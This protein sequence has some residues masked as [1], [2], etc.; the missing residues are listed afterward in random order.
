MSYI[1]THMQNPETWYKWTY[2]Q[3]RNRNAE[4]ENEQMDPGQG[5]KGG[6][7]D[8]EIGVTYTR[9]CVWSRSREAAASD[10]ELS[11]VSVMT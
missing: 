1:N 4:V 11:V 10:G 7:M 8:W 5:Q 3:G 6:G 2:L 9:C